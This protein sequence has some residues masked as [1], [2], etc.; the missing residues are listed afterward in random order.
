MW[1]HVSELVRYA[2]AR[3]VSLLPEIDAPGHTKALCAPGS[4]VP[5]AA[6]IAGC[7]NA[8]W[9]LRLG[10]A[11]LAMMGALWDEVGPGG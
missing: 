6:C 7:S 1:L 5:A 8:N 9:P 11:S 10:N 2:S 3:G 4:G